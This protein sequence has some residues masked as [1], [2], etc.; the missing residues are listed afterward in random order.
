MKVR[1][2][3]MSKKRASRVRTGRER[4]GEGEEGNE[5]SARRGGGAAHVAQPRLT[6]AG[7]SRGRGSQKPPQ[8]TRDWPAPGFNRPSVSLSA[9]VA[10]PAPSYVRARRI[11]E[12]EVED[13]PRVPQRGGLAQE[14]DPRQR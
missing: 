7:G 2:V 8:A 10:L 11:P 4:E 6:K 1:M 14:S 5:L 13:E 3:A 9:P 12:L